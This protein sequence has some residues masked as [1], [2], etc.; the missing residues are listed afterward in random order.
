GLGLLI[1]FASTSRS[2][3]KVLL[4]E[5]YIGLFR[6]LP[7]ILVIFAVFYGLNILIRN[8]GGWTGVPIPGM[9]P[10]PAIVIALVFQFSAY[11]AVVFKDWLS[12]LP[13]GLVEAGLA[14]GM[15]DNKVR[16]RIVVPLI[17]RHA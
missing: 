7:E 1:A 9:P 3:L 12:T 5:L 14:I 4:A 15:S 6:G 17:L 13:K 8:V 10:T 16:L 11:S 2:R